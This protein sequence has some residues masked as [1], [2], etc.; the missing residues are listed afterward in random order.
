LIPLHLDLKGDG[1]KETYLWSDIHAGL[2]LKVDEPAGLLRPVAGLGVLDIG[3]HPFKPFEQLPAVWQDAARRFSDK[4]P[5]NQANRLLRGFGWADANGDFKIQGDELRLKP[6]DGH[7]FGGSTSSCLLLDDALT[8][9]QGRGYSGENQPAWVRF[10]AQGRTSTGAPVW[11]WSNPVE[12]RWRRAACRRQG[13]RPG[14]RVFQRGGFRRR[15][16]LASGRPA[17][18]V[19]AG[20]ERIRLAG[21][22]RKTSRGRRTLDG[23]A[24]A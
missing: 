2:L 16:G 23:N 13:P 21:C 22:R 12:A 3:P 8:I 18:L 4:I 5:T 10:P 19:R 1:K 9:Y 7:G 15:T 24:G 11:D 14:G 20:A 17:A 6:S